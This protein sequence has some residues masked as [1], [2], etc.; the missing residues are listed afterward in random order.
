MPS[1]DL[2]C[3]MGESFGSYL[4]DRDELL[5]KYITSANI[6]CG[7]HAGDP[8]IMRRTVRLCLKHGVAIGAHPGLPD[9]AGFGRRKLQITVDEAYEMVVYQVG[10]L[11]GFVLAE[12]AVLQH[13]KPHGA[14]YNMA[15]VDAELS[16][17]IAEA[18][19]RIDSRLILFGLAGS[20][21]IQAGRK[22]GLR[23][24][25]EAFVD[26]TYRADGTL[27]PRSEPNAVIEEPEQAISQAIGLIKEGKVVT[28]K[29]SISLRADT[30]CIHGDTPN[31]LMFAELISSRL[32]QEGVTLQAA[33]GMRG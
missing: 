22:M 18:V 7:Y 1:V 21:L 23:V 31:A 6:A 16:V 25:E 17:A 14:L 27:T 24:A 10:A 13:V 30:L 19:Y 28:D 20:E 15:A 32:V 33:A 29:G 3:D 2:N 9:L 11:M 5:M 12:G 26:R 8:A 4:V